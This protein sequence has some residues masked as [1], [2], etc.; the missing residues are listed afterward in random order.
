MR[1]AFAIIRS[2][3]TSILQTYVILLRG[4]MPTG[5][6][7]VPMAPLRTALTNA[8]FHNVQ[9]YIQSGNVIAMSALSQTEIEQAIHAI[10]AREFGGDIVVMART[11]EQFRILFERN[12]FHAADPSHVYFTVLATK[13]DQQA[14]ERLLA[15]DYAPDQFVIIDD[16]IYTLYATKYSDSKFNNALIER[17]LKLAAT[18]RNYNTT[19]KLVKLSE[20]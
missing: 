1:R 18:T 8:G 15:L 7:N 12:P 3:N 13:P 5:K 10:I 19:A 6:N 2:M 20:Q 11:H 4:V 14:L 9:T 17:K 16:V